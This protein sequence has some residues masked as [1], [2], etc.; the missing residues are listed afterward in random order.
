HRLAF[1][2]QLCQLDFERVHAGDMMHDDADLAPVLGEM[3]LPLGVGEGAREGGKRAGSLLEAI[4]KGVGTLSPFDRRQAA[5]VDRHIR[6]HN[7]RHRLILSTLPAPHR[8]GMSY[9]TV[10]P[11]VRAMS[12]RPIYLA[13]RLQLMT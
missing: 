9:L 7:P 10:R 11:R 13:A 12:Q 5:G 4:G 6:P 1:G 3:G 2:K 8:A